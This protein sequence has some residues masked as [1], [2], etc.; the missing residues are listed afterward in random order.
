MSVEYYFYNDLNKLFNYA[1]NREI[2]QLEFNEI[3]RAYDNLQ[4]HIKQLLHW[5]NTALQLSKLNGEANAD[6]MRLA[7]EYE[8]TLQEIGGVWGEVPDRI[9]PAIAL[10]KKRLKGKE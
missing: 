6:A 3:E 4:L 8:K 1:V 10:H 7:T 2:T 9:S 5:R